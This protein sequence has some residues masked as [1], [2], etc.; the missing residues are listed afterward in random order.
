MYPDLRA[1]RDLPACQDHRGR[2][3]RQHHQGQRSLG[4]QARLG[5]PGRR[6]YLDRRDHRACP[7]HPD[8][9]AHGIR[10]LPVHRG[11]QGRPRVGDSQADDTCPRP[12]STDDSQARPDLRVRQGLLARPAGRDHPDRRDPRS[13]EAAGDPDASP[14][15]D[16]AAD[17]SR[18]SPATPGDR[19]SRAPSSRNCSRHCPPARPRRRSEAPRRRPC[20]WSNSRTGA[21][22][23][24]RDWPA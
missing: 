19:P 11:R 18:D 4:H 22:R 2:P 13:R 15:D 24:R 5:H 20:R 21:R 8:R 17:A 6:A 14:A 23:S 7:D 12:A 9:P 16:G 1:C 3:V 10:D